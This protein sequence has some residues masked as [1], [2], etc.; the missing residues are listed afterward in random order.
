MELT[1]GSGQKL[2]KRFSENEIY[3]MELI[4]EFT[5]C[6]QKFS[7]QPLT[8]LIIGVILQLEQRRGQREIR[9]RSSN[10]SS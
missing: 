10:R 5:K 9:K 6:S 2:C 4:I 1:T 7:T 8:W 3:I